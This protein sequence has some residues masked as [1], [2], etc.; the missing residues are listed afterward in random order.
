MYL[1][2]ASFA[3]VLGRGWGGDNGRIDDRTLPHQQAALLQH[4][5]DFLE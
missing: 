1:G 5:A 3:L 2:V 4:R